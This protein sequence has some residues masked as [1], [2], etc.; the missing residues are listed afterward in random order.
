MRGAECFLGSTGEASGADLTGAGHG[1]MPD[2]ALRILQVSTADVG[3]GAERVA[4]N[5]FTRY[6]ARGH[7]AW[8]AVGRKRS[9]DPHVV[10]VPNYES[11]SLWYRLL[12]R[13]ASQPQP[14]Y[15]GRL[16]GA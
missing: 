13:V 10:A 14:G 2:G 5:L 7:D 15:R 12:A 9:D 11:R 8:L 16:A 1:P 6:R 4:W 3:G